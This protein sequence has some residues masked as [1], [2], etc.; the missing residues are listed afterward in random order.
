LGKK[1]YSH[2]AIQFFY[3]EEKN[4][5]NQD[6]NCDCRYLPEIPFV[7]PRDNGLLGVNTHFYG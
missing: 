7:P 5:K 2:E 4:S 3:I 1:L 6:K